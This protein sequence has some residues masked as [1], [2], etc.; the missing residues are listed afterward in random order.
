[1]NRRVW[2]A[3]VALLTC[4]AQAALAA[5]ISVLSA[6][7]IEPG[8][9]PALAAFEKASGHNIVLTFA[10]APQIRQRIGAGEVFDVVIAPPAVLDE[11]EKAAKVG[12][13]RA[14]IG[15]V[16]IGV[17]VRPG[18]PLPDISSAEA[19]KRAVLEADSLVFNRASTGLYFE[20]LLKKMG[21]DAQA[22]PKSTRYPDGASVM[23]H[24][25]HGKGR[26]IGF[27]AITEI[28]LLQGK[29]LQLVGPL[30]PELQN[31][32]AYAATPMKGQPTG[33]VQALMQHLA[34]AQTRA[35]FAA[36]GIDQAP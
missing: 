24:V 26:E 21:L 20:G 22:L 31:L 12:A 4:G 1:M 33:D 5:Q 9:R 6:G 32:T 28:V 35:G 8:I 13:G 7:A 14:A 29:G 17:A 36:A 3:S 30:P 15:R 10:T 25:L 27:G 34:N 16:G 11:L 23:E 2:L 19:V 18:A